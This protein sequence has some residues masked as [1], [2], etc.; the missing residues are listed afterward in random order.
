M[1]KF[2]FYKLKSEIAEKPLTLHFNHFSPNSLIKPLNDFNYFQNNLYI[3]IIY[4][5]ASQF[6]IQIFL[7]KN[8]NCRIP[9][10][11]CNLII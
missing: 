11:V 10:I 9:L 3:T 5:N 6:K 7:T 4:L 2:R 1:A 8:P